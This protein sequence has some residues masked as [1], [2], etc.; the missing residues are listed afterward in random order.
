[1]NSIGVWATL[2]NFVCASAWADCSTKGGSDRWGVKTSIVHPVSTAKAVD[3]K[4]LLELQN[5]PLTKAQKQD[6]QEHRLPRQPG[7]DM[8]E[9]DIVTV[10]GVVDRVKCSADDDD[11]HLQLRTEDDATRCLIA[12]IPNG[13]FATQKAL[14]KTVDKYRKYIRDS[15]YGGK[16]PNGKEPSAANKK[17]RITGQLF[18]D[19]HHETKTSPGGGRGSGPCTVVNLWEIHPITSIEVIQ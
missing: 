11:Y 13:K 19:S 5:P 7:A 14:A 6:L 3:L 9:G 2:I 4:T 12:E 8:K 17:A 10:E 18:F 1:M 15:L 16:M